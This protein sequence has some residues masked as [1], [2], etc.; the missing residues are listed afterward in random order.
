M[1]NYIKAKEKEY[2]KQ[3]QS[4]DDLTNLLHNDNMTRIIDV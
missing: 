4:I 2:K 1:K 3:E